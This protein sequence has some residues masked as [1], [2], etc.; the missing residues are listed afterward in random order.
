MDIFD[1][2]EEVKRRRKERGM[3]QAQLAEAAGLSR[4]RI[5]D[6]E[7]GNLFEM[8]FG[9][10]VSVLNALDLDFRVGEHNSGR[11]VFEELRE[12]REE[13]PSP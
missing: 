4:G 10:L 1:I 13:D 3:T 12:S 9:R 6:L 2:G 8:R 5:V 7:N 11:P